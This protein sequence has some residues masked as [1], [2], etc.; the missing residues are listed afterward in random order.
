MEEIIPYK[1]FPMRNLFKHVRFHIRKYLDSTFPMDEAMKA[2][3]EPM[4]TTV[5]RRLNQEKGD[6]PRVADES[7]VPYQT[8]TKIAG[9]FVRNPRICTVQALFDYFECRPEQAAAIDSTGSAH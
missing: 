2:N 5:L 9:G 6:W 1:E 8:I 7:E 4:L 3:R